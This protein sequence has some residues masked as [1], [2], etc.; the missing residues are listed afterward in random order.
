MEKTIYASALNSN[1]IEAL[2]EPGITRT[3]A[4]TQYVYMQANGT[5]SAGDVVVPTADTAT[6]STTSTASFVGVAGVVYSGISDHYF[7]WVAKDGPVFAKV[8]ATGGIAVGDGI[9]TTT[10]TGKAAKTTAAAGDKFG[11]ALADATTDTLV[12]CYVQC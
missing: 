6:V 3:E 2:D 11:Y 5:L 12:P 7:G 1:S 8:N 4:G 9:K 10:N